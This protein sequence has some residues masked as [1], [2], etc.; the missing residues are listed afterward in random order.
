MSLIDAVN[1]V[2]KKLIKS[3]E[4]RMRSDVPIA[5]CLSGGIDSSLLA[6]HAKKTFDKEISTFSIIDKDPDMM[7]MKI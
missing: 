5:F 4:L 7:S 2:K 6:S 3:L 1:G